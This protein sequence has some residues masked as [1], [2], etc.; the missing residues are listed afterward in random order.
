M[1]ARPAPVAAAETILC[2]TS[3]VSVVQSAAD[4]AR[5]AL[6]ISVWPAAT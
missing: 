4:N 6:S 5:S 3:F 2:D 1:S